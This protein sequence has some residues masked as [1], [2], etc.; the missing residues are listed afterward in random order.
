[1]KSV[2]SQISL[3]KASC[4]IFLGLAFQWWTYSTCSFNASVC[5]SV[6][7]WRQ[8]LSVV[9]R[10]V[11]I[12]FAMGNSAQSENDF[13][14]FVFKE[15]SVSAKFVVVSSSSSAFFNGFFTAVVIQNV[16]RKCLESFDWIFNFLDTMLLN[17][18]VVSSCVSVG[19]FYFNSGNFFNFLFLLV[20]FFVVGSSVA[21]SVSSAVKVSATSSMGSSAF[22]FG[23]LSC[24]FSS[25]TRS[26]CLS[27]TS[28]WASVE[29]SGAS[30][31][32]SKFF[33]A[34]LWKFG[35]ASTCL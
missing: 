19:G 30:C 29:S 16:V 12:T 14:V 28:S 15:D 22:L 31:R 10:S 26:A 8:F 2:A 17:S 9:F 34:S 3:S 24:A 11:R 35:F 4:L 1:M 7:N 20:S 32:A 18:Y 21:S 23:F 33:L 27:Q 5:T 13:L 6:C 25:C